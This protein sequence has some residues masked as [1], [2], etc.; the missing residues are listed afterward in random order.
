MQDTWTKDLGSGRVATYTIAVASEEIRKRYGN[1][2]NPVLH[3]CSETIVGETPLDVMVYYGPPMR[4]TV[5][6]G[7]RSVRLSMEELQRDKEAQLLERR[8]Q[9]EAERTIRR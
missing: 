2:E 4:E 6:H 5:E 7:F 9:R 8:A 3:E 1:I